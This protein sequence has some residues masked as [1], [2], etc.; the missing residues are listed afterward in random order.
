MIV[1]RGPSLIVLRTPQMYNEVTVP[2][3]KMNEENLPEGA[4]GRCG[5][6]PSRRWNLCVRCVCKRLQVSEREREEKKVG[7]QV[8]HL[9]GFRDGVL[10]F[11]L[12][13]LFLFS[14]FFSS[15]DYPQVRINK[16]FLVILLKIWILKDMIQ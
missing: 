7:C 3:L 12:L 4:G 9:P 14:P 10:P 5:M 6:C 11:F 8:F 13:K 2:A 15:N 1:P 16:K